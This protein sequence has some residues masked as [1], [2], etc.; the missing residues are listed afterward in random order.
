MITSVPALGSVGVIKDALPQELPPSAL[1]DVLNMRFKDGNAAVRIDGDAQV[2]AGTSVTPYYVT[3]YSNATANYIVHAG[4][5]AVYAY[6][7][8]TTSD[9]TGTAFT[10]ASTDRWSG[11]TLNGVLVLNNGK[12]VPRYWG[13]AGNTASLPG[14][15]AN[16]KCAALRPFKSYLVALDVTKSGTRYPT[17]VKWSAA[18]DPGYVPSSW[19]ETDPTVEAGENSLAETSDA[20]IDALPLGDTLIIYKEF[21]MYAMTY[22]GGQFIWQFRR[23]PGE[24]GMLARGCGAITPMGHVVLTTND[25]VLMNGD[26]ATSLLTGKMR[27]WLFATMDSSNRRNSFVVANPTQNEVWVCFPETGQSACTKA[28]IWNWETKTFSIRELSGATYG[29]SGNFSSATA[30]Y[31]ST[32]ES[33]ILQADSGLTFHGSAF[34]AKVER[35][36]MSFGDPNR[37][38][39]VRAVYPRI[40]GASG[41][42]V[43]VQVGATMDPEAAYTWATAVPYTIGSTR[44]AP[45]FVSGRLIGLRVYSSSSY[46]WRVASVD[47]DIEP[48]GMY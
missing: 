1:T 31:L 29:A 3:L 17:L 41:Q 20:C 9:I 39:L 30:L 48:R 23:I 43:Y 14:W 46:A 5:A 32:T 36:G 42:T 34:T 15:N 11:G 27:N 47:L 35:T 2:G 6:N 4:T 21:S 16:H 38:K 8:S 28:L 22:I 25:V 45:V 19:D 18:A 7:G 13:G 37:V 40:D 12:D 10:G 44:K 33:K 24:S 26:G